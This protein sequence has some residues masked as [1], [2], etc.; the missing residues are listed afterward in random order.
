MDYVLKAM[1][2]RWWGTHKQSISKWPQCIIL[3]EIG[4]GENISYPDNKHTVL[5]DPMEHIEH[6]G[7]NWKEYPRQGWVH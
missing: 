2:A 1:P 5:T 4:F 3:L 6:C 7:K